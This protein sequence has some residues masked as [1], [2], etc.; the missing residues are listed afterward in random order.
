VDQWLTALGYGR[1][2]GLGEGVQTDDTVGEFIGQLDSGELGEAVQEGEQLYWKRSG[3][4]GELW[5]P[6]ES[7]SQPWKA[8]CRESETKLLHDADDV[9][10]GCR[11]SGCGLRAAGRRKA[12]VLEDMKL[13][14]STIGRLRHVRVFPAF[15]RLGHPL[16][17]WRC[18]GSPAFGTVSQSATAADCTSCNARRAGCRD[19]CSASSAS[20][21]SGGGNGWTRGARREEGRLG[22][23]CCFWP[24][25]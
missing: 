14:R 16:C 23:P 24:M 6:C 13:F 7:G 19:R 1:M 20:S 4:G 5:V 10:V 21:P 25:L 9:G 15:S 22:E 8:R 17:S 11:T 2:A 18:Q 12:R 3:N